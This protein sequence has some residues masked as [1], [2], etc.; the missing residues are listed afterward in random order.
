[1][2]RI[3]LRVACLTLALTIAVLGAPSLPQEGATQRS[4]PSATPMATIDLGGLFGDENEPDENEA[5]EGGAEGGRS[6][7]ESRQSPGV[8]LPAALV[9]VLVAAIAGGYI[10]IRV[11]R[12]WLRLRGWG[13]DL[14][15]RL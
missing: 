11:R 14:R 13:S 6:S 4:A 5:D 1:V 9:L 15:A 2:I 12:L 7:G 8:S 10:A 3:A